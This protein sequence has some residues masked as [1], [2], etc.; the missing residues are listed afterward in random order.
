MGPGARRWN[1]KSR[2]FP[3]SLPPSLR[4]EMEK[5]ALRIRN[6]G[7]DDTQ[8]RIE[9]SHSHRLLSIHLGKTCGGEKVLST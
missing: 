3:P 1:S 2:A 5:I 4:M 8:R 6:R 7:T 9:D